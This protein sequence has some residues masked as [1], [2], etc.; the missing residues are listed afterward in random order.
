MRFLLGEVIDIFIMI[1]VLIIFGSLL[2]ISVLEGNF[3]YL[4]F[5]FVFLR[6]EVEGWVFRDFDGVLYGC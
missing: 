1:F 2:S 5:F 3:I 6:G 4:Y